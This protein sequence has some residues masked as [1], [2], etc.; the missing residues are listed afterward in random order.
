MCTAL[1]LSGDNTIA[2]NKYIISNNTLP[3]DGIWT[4]YF[5]NYNFNKLK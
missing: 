5:I 3:Y 2:V 4:D 1:L